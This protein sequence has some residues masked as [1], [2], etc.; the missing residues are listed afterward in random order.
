MHEVF[1]LGQLV[2]DV[3]TGFQGKV[4]AR[5][6]YLYDQPS[7]NVQGLAKDGKQGEQTWIQE[8]KCR[9]ISALS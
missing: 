1:E 7:L 6:E 5:V 9:S 8:G 2:E 3:V 4:I